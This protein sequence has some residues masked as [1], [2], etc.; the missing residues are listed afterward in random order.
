MVALLRTVQEVP[1]TIT[2]SE[3]IF[4]KNILFHGFWTIDLTENDYNYA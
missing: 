3:D 4:R 2:A 1:G